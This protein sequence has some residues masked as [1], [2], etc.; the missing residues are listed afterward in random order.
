VPDG[1]DDKGAD[2]R[3]QHAGTLVGAV[4]ANAL[5]YPRRDES[6]RYPSTA[7]RRNPC[8]LFG[9]GK[10]KRAITPAMRPTTTIQMTPSRRPPED[11]T[12]VLQLENG[13]GR[14]EFLWC[15]PKIFRIPMIEDSHRRPG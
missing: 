6:A 10:M 11:Q 15:G 1:K 8:G 9:P 12:V 3:A 4:P 5:A 7:V 2:S 13:N 14:E